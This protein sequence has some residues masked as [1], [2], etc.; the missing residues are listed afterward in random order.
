MSVQS[1]KIEL[2][3]WL[4]SLQDEE[5]ILYLK[6]LKDSRTSGRDWWKDLSEEQKHS[7]CR[8][9]EDSNEGRYLSNEEAKKKLGL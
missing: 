2:I 7:I 5:T 9:V 8:G 4:T 1:I 6:T 3:E